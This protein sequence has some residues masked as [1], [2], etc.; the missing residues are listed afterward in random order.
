M[1]NP[2]PH[3]FF[4]SSIPVFE[5]QQSENYHSFCFLFQPLKQ[6]FRCIT[7][8]MGIPNTH[9]SYV[10]VF[11]HTFKV[12]SFNFNHPHNY[13][14][15]C[16]SL[17]ASTIALPMF[18]SCHGDPNPHSSYIQYQTSNLNNP[19]NNHTFCFSL[20]ASTIALPMHNFCHGKP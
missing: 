2:Y 16:F 10:H 20:S 11:V 5:S 8:A 7:L 4:S 3:S 17:S 12:C 15:F 13:H 1:G 6:H 9:S 19:D 18:N 14:T